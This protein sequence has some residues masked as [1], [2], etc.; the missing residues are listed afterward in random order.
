MRVEVVTPPERAVT[1]EEA[2]SQC[3]VDAVEELLL[4]DGMI[5][6][7]QAQIE[8]PA[9]WLGRSVGV[10]TLEAYLPAPALMGRCILPCRPVIEVESVEA[11]DG[12]G[13]T[14][15]DPATYERRGDWLLF[16]ASAAP[17]AGWAIG[18]PE[19]IRVR[20][21]AGYE[22]VPAPIRQAIL[23]LTECNYRNRGSSDFSP[24][25]AVAVLLQPFRVY[26]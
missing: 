10:Q 4:L 14:L 18:D 5:A 19:G 8:A 6:A 11:R 26:S 16:G 21:R 25:A 13:W 12:G 24:P 23:L 22:D 1:L 3:R 20:Y 9:G 15:I 7:A 17:T 2:Q